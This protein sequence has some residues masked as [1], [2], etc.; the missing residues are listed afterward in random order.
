MS[1]ALIAD[2][3]LDMLELLRAVLTMAGHDVEAVTDGRDAVERLR[4]RTFDFA[5][6]DVQMPGLSG[7]EVLAETQDLEPRRPPVI[8]LS[9]LTTFQDRKRGLAAGAS[10][11]LAKPFRVSEFRRVV[12]DLIEGRIEE[13][14]EETSQ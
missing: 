8:M 7:L 3:D 2:D 9:G 5:V 6:L 11:Y 1:K 13:R 12:E 10:V 14:A 4:S